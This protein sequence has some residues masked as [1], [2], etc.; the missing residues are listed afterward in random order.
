M[1]KKQSQSLESKR[2]FVG[3]KPGEALAKW[4][5][6]P[7]LNPKAA[8][9]LLMNAQV[10]YR[11]TAEYPTLHS[12]NAARKQQKLPPAFWDSY[13]ELNDALAN[14]AFAPQIDLHQ[15]EDGKRVNWTLI[16]ENNRITIPTVQ[17]RW[18]VQLIE[19]GAILKIRRCKQ[20]TSW[21]FAHFSHQEFCK[22]SCRIKHFAGSEEFKEKRCKYMRKY[23]KLQKT[24]NVK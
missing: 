18:L 2:G 24:K 13:Q 10:V 22:T 19:Q 8:E 7:D 9:E 11:W 23:Y 14:F 16:A 5:N 15:L 4:L 21:F 3:R 20:C 6:Q 12:L 17:V 1:P